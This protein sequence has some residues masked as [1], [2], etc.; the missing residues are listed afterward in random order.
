MKNIFLA[1]L[2]ALLGA[3]GAPAFAQAAAAPDFARDVQPIFK[4]HCYECHGPDKHRSGYRLDRRS[5]AFKGSLKHNIIAGSSD[6][7][8]L[9]RRVLD[10]R[11]GPQMPLEDSLS[12]EEIDTIRRWIDAGAPWPDELANESDLPPP[13]AAAVRL[14]A[15]IRLSVFDASSRRKALAMVRAKPAVVN[16]RGAGGTTPLMEAALYG[17]VEL[18]RTLL[19]AGGDPNLRNYRAASALMWAVD[20]IAKV[21][22]LLDRG[23]DPNVSS[24]FSATALSLGAAS[25]DCG[26]PR[27]AAAREWRGAPQAA[28]N[29]AARAN[30]ESLRLLLAR[31][32]DK[33]GA[34]ATDGVTRALR[35]VPRAA[36]QG[37][38]NR[39]A[40]RA[41]GAVAPVDVRRP[42]PVARR[43]AAQSGRQHH[44][45]QGPHAAHDGQHL[46]DGDAGILSGAHRSRRERECAEH[47]GFQC[48]RLCVAARPH[49]DHRGAQARRAHASFEGGTTETRNS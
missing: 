49:A 26:A 37:S 28:L 1:A 31:I 9:Y 34:A 15:F 42:G 4:E 46:G 13:D 22:L 41:S 21:R 14:A 3:S 11:L 44:R 6:S 20:D 32:P 35:R 48:A 45:R 23:A 12:P 43:D 8:R 36:A 33:G 17:D 19:D 2:V 7:S 10:S 25:K 38:E 18:L 27:E 39:D 30:P 29:A 16:A 40:A 47:R 24:D 5:G